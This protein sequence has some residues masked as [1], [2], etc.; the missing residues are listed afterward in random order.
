[1]SIAP[2]FHWRD[3]WFFLRLPD[4]SVQVTPGTDAEAVV[5]LP[6]EWVSIIAAVRGTPYVGSTEYEEAKTFHGGASEVR[7]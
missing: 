3:G 4:G 1:M 2:G 6:H 7:R 5:I